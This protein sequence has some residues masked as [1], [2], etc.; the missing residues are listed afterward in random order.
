MIF[1]Q[2]DNVSG[3]ATIQYGLNNGAP[4][5]AAPTFNFT[6]ASGSVTENLASFTPGKYSIDV[7]L[8]G[9]TI[10]QAYLGDFD[11]SI[12][13]IDVPYIP[14]AGSYQGLTWAFNPYAGIDLTFD[15]DFDLTD[16]ISNLQANAYLLSLD[17]NT[18]GIMDA[19]VSWS[20]LRVELN[21]IPEPSTF[22]LFGIGI[23][24]FAMKRKVLAKNK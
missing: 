13:S 6:G 22:L 10:D 11:F 16:S 20:S 19:D 17:P 23:L 21:S 12:A 24:G 1:Y 15:F 5:S 8:V 4:T 14:L 18:N 3:V 2:A 7:T 9:L